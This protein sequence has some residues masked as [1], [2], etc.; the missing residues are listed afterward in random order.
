M[1]ECLKAFRHVFRNSLCMCGGFFL[2]NL[3]WRLE[4][5][6]SLYT[7]T[8]GGRVAF[9]LRFVLHFDD[10]RLEN[11]YHHQKAKRGYIPLHLMPQLMLFLNQRS[12]S[13]QSFCSSV[14]QFV[15]LSAKVALRD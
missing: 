3:A 12:T 13:L 15:S 8:L 4:G 14:R 10:M 5:S 1:K 7:S 6:R 2:I 11:D 9:F